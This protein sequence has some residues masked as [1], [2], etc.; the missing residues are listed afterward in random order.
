VGTLDRAAAGWVRAAAASVPRLRGRS[1]RHRL[2]VL[3]LASALV[4][5]AVLG[6]ASLRLLVHMG[7]ATA[8][9]AASAFQA[10]SAGRL[11]TQV[12]QDAQPLGAA[13]LGVEQQAAVLAEQTRYILDNPGLF[14]GAQQGNTPFTRLPDGDL[15][16]TD[17]TVGVFAPAAAP[18]APGFWPEVSLLTHVD[19]LLRSLAGVSCCLQPVVRYWIQAPDGLVRVDPNPGFA[20]GLRLQPQAALLRYFAARPAA[21]LHSWERAVWTL[22]YADPA[23]AR[24][25]DAGDPEIVSVVVPIYTAAG[26]FAGLAGADVASLALRDDL[27]AVVQPPFTAALLYRPLLPGAAVPSPPYPRPGAGPLAA[28]IIARTSAAMPVPAAFGVPSGAAGTARVAS[29]ASALEVAYAPMGTGGWMLAEAGPARA[30]D[31][32]TAAGETALRRGIARTEAVAAAILLGVTLLLA[33]GLAVLAEQAAGTVA[34]PLRRLAAGIRRTAGAGGDPEAPPVPPPLPPR[35]R[36]R[37]DTDEVALLSREFAALHGRLEAAVRRWRAEAEERALA[38]T[39]ALREK[40]RIALD[41]HD[42][43]AQAFLSI[44]LLCE[45]AGGRLAQVGEVARQGLRQARRSIAEL[46]P[47]PEAPGGAPFVAAVREEVAAFPQSLPDPPAVTVEVES[48]PDLP[49][50]VQVALLGVLRAA[51]GNVREHAAARRVRVRLRG[52]DDAAVLEVAD[53]GRGF[54]PRAARPGPGRGRGLPGMRGRLAE[55]GG[56]LVVE[57]RPGAGAVVRAVVPRGDAPCA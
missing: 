45:G 15:I 53:D 33:L 2:R 56:T 11:E 18:D 37:D 3:L 23:A 48:W 13:L 38:E 29:G 41:I 20:A 9:A 10:R 43:L 24:S 8:A 21:G 17:P 1:L 19:P 44:V 6:A 52:E 36:G 14:P 31:G 46:A 26:G 22:P 28:A 50:P 27:A 12:Q 51:L 30:V 57:S 47:E 54:D 39:A 40:Q 7:A 55:V 16:N 25:A 49:L 4:P 42:T 35:R 5:T 34:E 32:A